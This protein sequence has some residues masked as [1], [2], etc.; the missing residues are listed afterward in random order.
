MNRLIDKAFSIL[1]SLKFTV[2]IVS[3]LTIVFILGFFIPQKLIVPAEQY[4]IWK[5]ANPGLV[6]II[7]YLHFTEIYTA[8][9]TRFL[10]VLFFSNLTI[11]FLMRASYIVRRT[12][13]PSPAGVD[14]V[15]LREKGQGVIRV[16]GGKDL[17]NSVLSELHKK[18]FHVL[19]ERDR[20]IAV[21]NRYSSLCTIGFHLCFI[22]FL[23]GAFAAFYTKFSG[24]LI[25][26]EGEVFTGSIPQYSSVSLPR[27]GKPPSLQFQVLAIRPVTSEGRATALYVDLL[28]KNGEKRTININQPLKE[29][30]TSYVVKNLG[31]S[32]LFV[33][34]D[35][36]GNDV[37]G[38][39]YK[40]AVLMKKTDIFKLGNYNVDVV[41]YPDYT[42]RD[43]EALN[44]GRFSPVLRDP[45]FDMFVY[46]DSGNAYSGIV[47]RGEP[48]MLDGMSLS[49]EEI[50]YWVE[51]YVRK[52]RGT[53]FIYAGFIL[54]IVSLMLRFG[55][56]RKEVMGGIDSGMICLK[57]RSDFYQFQFQEELE[58][59][60]DCAAGEMV[61]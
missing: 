16:S 6:R 40:L 42:G 17:F 27:T 9:L 2:I 13:L 20:F 32:P 24:K 55:F 60:V 29:G 31:I 11:V 23:L 54:G 38:A 39:Y 49:F 22:L 18:R 52:D 46:D 33:L 53:A 25:L 35:T 1:S 10:F 37:A 30:D 61:R 48:L 58:G 51:F 28:M 8:P 41:F 45:V 15:L 5:A 59:L 21:K 7:E 4:G 3:L 43:N 56:P 57:G 12:F 34:R 36:D 47:R 26:A 44:G 50:P 19:K 14:P